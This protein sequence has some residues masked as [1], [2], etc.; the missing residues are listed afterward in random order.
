MKECSVSTPTFYYIDQ[1]K[2]LLKFVGGQAC[3]LYSKGHPPSRSFYSIFYFM[4]KHHPPCPCTL[5]TP[6][7]DRYQSVTKSDFLAP[8]TSVPS[9]NHRTLTFCTPVVDTGGSIEVSD[10]QTD[11]DRADLMFDV[12]C[13]SGPARSELL[14]PV[15][16]PS[17]GGSS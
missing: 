16:V 7:T 1:T 4:M 2:I 10:R 13:P 5:V 17:R 6:E 11:R 12:L 14:Q 3:I 15:V 8:S 9:N